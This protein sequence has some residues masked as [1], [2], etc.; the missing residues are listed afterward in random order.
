MP[1]KGIPSIRRDVSV[2]EA[3]T[4]DTDVFGNGTQ[5][6][7]QL[8]EG[9]AEF[10]TEKLLPPS[11]VSPGCTDLG[12]GVGYVNFEVLS[13]EPVREGHSSFVS[14]Q[15]L[16]TGNGIEKAPCIVQKRYSDFEKLNH[17][18]KKKFPSIMETVSFPGKVL[19]GNLKCETIAKRSRA[20]EQYLNHV[21]SIGEIRFSSETQMFFYEIELDTGFSMLLKEKYKEAIALLEQNL[22]IQEKILGSANKNVVKTI[23]ALVACSEA[24]EDR[25][26][27]LKFSTMGLS[28]IGDDISN[29]YY[30]P[31]LHSSIYL[32][33][34]LG[35]EKTHLEA[36]LGELREKGVA[37]ETNTHLLS[38]L[39]D[40]LRC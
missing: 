33:W 26:R 15:I 16:I 40:E 1:K 17:K 24:V 37:T 21:M 29:I 13:A 34:M 12:D 31:L 8:G 32:H 2:D 27:A 19:I 10:K 14:Y 7:L 30:L 35:R 28:C 18:L 39:L 11:P 5:L 25:E 6:T 3:L 4:D 36:K 38:I 9:D 20:F 22:P 23:C